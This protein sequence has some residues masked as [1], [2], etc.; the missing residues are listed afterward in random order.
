M[1]VSNLD[2]KYMHLSP[3]SWWHVD[4]CCFLPGTVSPTQT[5][6]SFQNSAALLAV[7]MSPVSLMGGSPAPLR[8]KMQ[9]KA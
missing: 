1:L 8:M 4:F 7:I 5:V 9:L 2:L 3:P 6:K